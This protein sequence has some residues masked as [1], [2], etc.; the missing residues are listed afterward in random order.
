MQCNS[1]QFNAKCN[2]TATAT[3][4]N[5][6]VN[7][8][9]NSMSSQCNAPRFRTRPTPIQSPY[10]SNACNVQCICNAMLCKYNSY[11]FNAMQ[12]YCNALHTV[13]PLLMTFNQCNGMQLANCCNAVH[14]MQLNFNAFAKCNAKS[15]QCNADQCKAYAMLSNDKCIIP[16]SMQSQCNGFMQLT[17]HMSAFDQMQLNVSKCN[18]HFH[19]RDIRRIRHLLPQLQLNS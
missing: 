7:V 14:A 3:A 4:T 6:N 2:S 18:C 9:F 13:P 17:L 16:V 1:M 5:C 10:N 8:K 11:K 19:I 15:M 12:C